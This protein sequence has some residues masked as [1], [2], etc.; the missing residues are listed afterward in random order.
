[1]K[2]EIL[3]KKSKDIKK[4]L[5][6]NRNIKN[7]REFFNPPDP[8]TIQLKALGI[9]ETATKK[10]I[11]RI[12]FAKKHKEQVV[13]YGDY[14]ADG[15][16]ATAILW[17]ALH[18]YGLDVLPHI[19]DRFSEGY[20]INADSL[21]NLK[22]KF[23]N[24]GLIVTIDNGI[25]A[26]EGIKKAKELGID[27]IVIDHHAKGTKKLGTSYILH[28]TKV[29]GS[30]LAYFFAKELGHEGGLE[31]A[32]IG[33]IADQMPLTGINR[34]IVK[35]GLKELENSKRPGL[36]ELLMNA[37]VKKV[38]TYEVN[39]IIAPRLN[40]MGRLAHALD[41]LRLL[42]TKKEDKAQELSN[43]LTKTN[44]ER[45]RIVDVVVKH[46]NESGV[47]ENKVIVLAHE[48]YHEG[49]IGLVAGKLVEEFYRPAI[50]ISRGEKISKASARSISGFDIISTIRNLSHLILEGGGHPMAAGFTI[51][52]KNIEKF[53]KEIN[54]IADKL[55]TNELLE[56]KLKIDCE[57]NFEE[58]NPELVEWV[59]AFEPFGNGNYP[60][61][62][63]SHKIEIENVRPV[64][65]NGKHLK[66]K[67]KQNSISFDA[68]WFN[69]T[70][71]ISDLRSPIS[72]AFSIEENVW[73]SQTTLQFKIKDI[74][75][76]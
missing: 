55:L 59:K 25:V 54:K 5:L 47:S 52:T 76:F 22:S 60:P 71:S 30:G 23:I 48:S 36:R 37:E 1:M 8:Y 46:T 43:L 7:E 24:L 65:T 61:V 51:E 72:I 63:V 33:T 18:E 44:L 19:P 68:I 70:A 6:K 75:T 74:K 69:A 27:V 16:C 2:W 29:C 56:K 53:T 3:E 9:K 42:C 34:S 31:L 64:G 12:K 13:V 14:D 35:Y 67:L 28:S 32:A 62:F 15:I 38:G 20:G 45:Q 57:I 73:Q 39:Y 17:E 11:D 26:Y 4:T 66:L 49:V 10:A 50:V 40:A 21:I 41:S 58:I